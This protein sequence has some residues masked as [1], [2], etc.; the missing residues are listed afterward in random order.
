MAHLSEDDFEKYLMGM[1]PRAACAASE[2]HLL[3]C[4]DCRDRLDETEL[5][6]QAIR[7]AA[8][9]FRA[10]KESDTDAVDE[11]SRSFTRVGGG[12]S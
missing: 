2:E 12:T 4:A 10:D 5:Y 3:L 8:A 1:L 7:A 9:T 6:V 11:L